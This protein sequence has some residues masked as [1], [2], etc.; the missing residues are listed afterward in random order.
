M[1]GWK[2]CCC[3]RRGPLLL[4]NKRLVSSH[5]AAAAEE[6]RTLKELQLDYSEKVAVVEALKLELRQTTRGARR[7]VM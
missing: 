6:E 3:S 4:L 7:G 5:R 2:Q 1:R